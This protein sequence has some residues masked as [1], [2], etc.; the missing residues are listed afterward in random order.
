V[1]RGFFSRWEKWAATIAYRTLVRDRDA[2]KTAAPPLR[3]RADSGLIALPKAVARDP[4]RKRSGLT[5]SAEG[6]MKAQRLNSRT[7]EQEKARDILRCELDTQR[8][9]KAM[10][11]E[12]A[13]V[14]VEVIRDRR[15]C[16]RL[17]SVCC[18]PR[19]QRLGSAAPGM[20]IVARDVESAQVGR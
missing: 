4:F 20:I 12:Y 7:S 11:A 14:G 1:Q 15:Q 2:S 16:E 13:K 9:D 6:I 8:L 5:N 18:G 10:A 19:G 17:N 3:G